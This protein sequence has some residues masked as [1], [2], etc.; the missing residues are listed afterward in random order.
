MILCGKKNGCCA[1]IDRVDKNT[2]V[3]RDDYGGEVKLTNT[4]YKLLKESDL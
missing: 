4:E 3:I 1:K 2:L